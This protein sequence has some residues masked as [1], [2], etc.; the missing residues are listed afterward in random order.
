[1]FDIPMDG[2]EGEL[3]LYL[4][5]TLSYLHHIAFHHIYLMYL[6]LQLLY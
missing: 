3:V 1:V 2:F 4:V 6:L 5:Y